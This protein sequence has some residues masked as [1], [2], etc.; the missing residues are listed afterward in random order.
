MPFNLYLEKQ[1]VNTVKNKKFYLMLKIRLKI[2]NYHMS[3]SVYVG[4]LK[5]QIIENLLRCPA[6]S[7]FKN[8]RNDTLLKM[9]IKHYHRELRKMLGAT[10]KVLDLAYARQRP[11]QMELNRMRHEAVHKTIRVKLPRLP[12]RYT[13][14]KPEPKEQ[15]IKQEPPI[16][17]ELPEKIPRSQDSPKLRLALNRPVKRP[18]VLLPVRKLDIETPEV[19]E[20]VDEKKIILLEPKLEVPTAEQ[21]DFEAAISTHTVTRPPGEK[22]KSDKKRKTFATISKRAMSED[23]EWFT[24]NNSDVETRSSCPRS[25]TPDSKIMEQKLVSSEYNE[26][27]KGANNYLYTECEYFFLPRQLHWSQIREFYYNN[28]TM[29]TSNN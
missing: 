21:L 23:E 2:L 16:K 26:E 5:V 9:H 10:P 15:D 7:C 19:K 24:M 1:K 25:G 17:S 14:P 27:Q 8:F 13:D 6:E 28:C 12:R 29:S 22:R 20:E 4:S 3:L 18:K 11:T